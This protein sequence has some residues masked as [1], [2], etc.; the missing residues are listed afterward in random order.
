MKKQLFLIL[1]SSS[2]NFSQDYIKELPKDKN[3]LFWLP[4]V[5]VEKIQEENFK[6]TDSLKY[7]GNITK[8][9][10]DPEGYLI[11][12]TERFIHAENKIEKKF[13]EYEYY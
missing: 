13:Y 2:L 5:K 7:W 6:T 1:I 11:K 8:N 4:K 9:Y 3:Q 10:Y 12:N